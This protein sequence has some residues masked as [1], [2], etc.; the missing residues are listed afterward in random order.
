MAVSDERDKE[1]IQRWVEENDSRAATE[2]YFKYN[3]QILS[4]VNMIIRNHH[5][6]EEITHD[7]FV[8]LIENKQNFLKVDD[9]LKYFIGIARNKINKIMPSI[10]LEVSIEL[11]Q[12]EVDEVDNTLDLFDEYVS[13]NNVKLILEAIEKLKPSCKMALYLDV[14]LGYT[15][16][17]IAEIMKIDIKTTKNLLYR[18][19]ELIKQEMQTKLGI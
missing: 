12:N 9:L 18:G 8:C 13:N 6:S 17:E 3:K 2:I 5:I 11:Y 14:K 15:N 1:L 10:G 19:K 4:F 16:K 7:V